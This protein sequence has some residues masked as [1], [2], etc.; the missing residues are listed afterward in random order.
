MRGLQNYIW[1]NKFKINHNLKDC[2]KGVKW[3]N[4]ISQKKTYSISVLLKQH[5]GYATVGICIGRI[6][7]HKQFIVRDNGF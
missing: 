2:Y 3:Q 7:I 6:G 1:N 5:I 4:N